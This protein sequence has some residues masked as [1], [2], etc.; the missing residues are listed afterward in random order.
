MPPLIEE[1]Y[2][3]VTCTY[4]PTV[5]VNN[6]SAG[7]RRED[8]LD[9]LRRGDVVGAASSIKRGASRCILSSV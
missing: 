6:P 5:S 4:Y 7:D 8:L 1:L 9:L 3:Q 2:N